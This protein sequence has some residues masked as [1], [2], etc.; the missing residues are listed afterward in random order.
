MMEGYV[1]LAM[2]VL[3]G[4]VLV[5]GPFVALVVWL[6]RRS[7]RKQEEH[8]ARMFWYQHSPEWIDHYPDPRWPR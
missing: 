1:A 8:K 7:K 3:I 2:G 4:L 5:C 6:A